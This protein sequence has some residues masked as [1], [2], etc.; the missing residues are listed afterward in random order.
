MQWLFWLT[1]IL[2]SKTVC[3]Q[4]CPSEDGSGP[5]VPSTLHGKLIY[6]EDLRTWHALKLD[7]KVC[8]WESIQVISTKLNWN[9]VHRFRGCA[10]TI[11]G[12]LFTPM[13]G[14]YSLGLA[15]DVD[16]IQPDDN[17]KLLPVQADLSKG[18]VPEACEKLRRDNQGR[19]SK[20]R[21]Y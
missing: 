6:H 20:W 8:N 2:S 1:L 5:G 3:A 4:V 16:K 14:Y 12:N 15:M 17:C 9:Y 19:L 13:T 10:V 21:T 18:P 11:T 7:Q